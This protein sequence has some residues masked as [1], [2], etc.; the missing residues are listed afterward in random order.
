[1]ALGADVPTSPTLTVYQDL[2]EHDG[3]Y[4]TLGFGHTFEDV[5][6]PA[7]DVSISVDLGATVAWG[8]RKHN[9]FYYGP[10]GGW[11]DATVTV[12]LPIAIGEHLTVTP[13]ASHMW[14]LDDGIRSAL[15]RG[16][17]FWAGLSVTVSF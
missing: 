2:D 9:E 12:G 5:W 17:A 13:Y 7:D 8:S 16:D 10:G 1:L 15:G 14:I 6:K 3:T 11:T 4:M